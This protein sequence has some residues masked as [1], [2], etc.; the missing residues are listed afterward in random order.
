MWRALYGVVEWD[1]DKASENAQKHGVSF[2]EA[3]TVFADPSVVTSFDGQH[4]EN[5]VRFRDLGFSASGRLLVVVHTER[6][7]RLRIISARN[8]TAREWKQ[9]EE[10]SR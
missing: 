8:A 5:E 4:S 2:E 10:H 9:Y 6:Q 3:A 1:A 7:S